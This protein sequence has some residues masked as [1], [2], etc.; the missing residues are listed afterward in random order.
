MLICADVHCEVSDLTD[1]GAL[2]TIVVA[3]FG[4]RN[5]PGE[6]VHLEGKIFR[7]N[8]ET[9]ASVQRIE[10][11]CSRGKYGGVGS[12]PVVRSSSIE[13]Q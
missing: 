9:L 11:S 12:K 1:S 7:L 10:E 13:A 6:A 8:A 3:R 5:A 4:L 2:W